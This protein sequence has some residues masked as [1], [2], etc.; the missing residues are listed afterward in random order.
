MGVGV[1]RDKG[2]RGKGNQFNLFKGH[3]SKNY[4]RILSI[5]LLRYCHLYKTFYYYYATTI[6]KMRS[7][8]S[9]L[10]LLRYYHL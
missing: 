4:S 7:T 5:A 2:E 8:A 3:R 10:L 9:A 6:F 1:G